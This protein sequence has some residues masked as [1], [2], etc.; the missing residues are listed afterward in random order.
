MTETTSKSKNKISKSQFKETVLSDYRL[1]SE[2][3]ESGAQGRRDVLSGKGSFGI[4]GDGKE[5]AQIALAKVFKDGDFRAGYY[6]DQTMM[7][8]LGQYSPKHMF[9]ALYGDP[10]L[11]REPSSGSRQMMNHFGTRF[12]NE[13]GSWKNLMKQKNSTSDMACL[14]SQFPR[15]VGLAQASK[16]YRSIP[17]LAKRNPGFTNNGNEVIFA[18]IGNSSC[19]E[20]HF[21]E[22]VNAIGVLQ[23]PAIISIWDDGY[24]ISVANDIQMTKSDVS[25]VLSGFKKDSK[26]EGFDIVKVKG[27]DYPALV[28]AYEKAEKLARDKHIPSIIHVIE[29]TQ[30]TGHS[31]SGSHERYKSKE[32]LQFE[33][34]FDCIKKFKEWIIETQVATLEE[35]ET[36][37]KQAIESVKQQKKEAWIEYQ[38]P[39]KEEWNELK[40]IFNSI[41][42]QV[43]ISEIP[44]WID[45][46]NQS[47]TFGIF[48][49]DFLSKAR[50]LLS[51]IIHE[52]IPEKN[53]LRNF[54]NRI[55]N[56]NY[57]RYNTKLYNETETSA[58]KVSEVKPSYDSDPELV[59]G[60]IVLRDNFHQ[61]FETIPEAMIFGEDVGKIGGV[62]QGCEGLQEKFGE[63]RVADTGIREATIIGQGIGLSLRG[64]KPIAEMQYLDYVIYGFQ[65]MVD[66]ISSLFYRTHGGQITPL[67]IRTRGHRLEGIWHSGSQ[68][69]M[70]IN[71]TR[72]IYL[73]VP[74]DM[75][76]AAG[77]YNTLM[78]SNDPA[79]IIECLNG[80]RIKEPLPNNIGEFRVPLGKIDITKEGSDITLVSYGSTWRVVMDAAKKL[81]NAGISAEVIDI[82]TLVPF[83]LSHDIV[84][85]VKKTNRILVV[86]EDVPGGASA[87]ILQKILEEQGAYAFLDSEPQTLPA[88]EHRP[89]YGKD[90]DYFTKPSAE[91]IFEKAYSIMHE[92][93]PVNFPALY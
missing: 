64:L 50:N 68:M 42:A 22:A 30:P 11:D 56:E 2:V 90:G 53:K 36:I 70:L 80:Y 45:D 91:D 55:N 32:R 62:N 44:K 57:Q 54:I 72:G 17:E 61:I 76:R 67:I 89:P 15:L 59:D 60:R 74:R 86:D 31:T 5:L 46:L 81:E 20:G 75:T 51:M 6:R 38:K 48:R 47:A 84:E 3:R 85:S 27:W 35:L 92:V 78:Q 13:D 77:F 1:A 18:T 65:P 28:A 71:G 10:E 58:L 24:G 52:D 41:S 79:M 14:A 4:F 83:D 73:C 19:A 23:V 21:F 37:D 49:R 8:A 25:E 93:N 12:L 88:K 26:G 43:N 29:M 16:V 7:T 82:Q 39:I 63:I 34:D 87:Y 66:D 33:Q 9:S 40:A 69:G